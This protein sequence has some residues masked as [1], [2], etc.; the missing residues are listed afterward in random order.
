LNI[1]CNELKIFICYRNAK[2]SKEKI[3]NMVQ[4]IHDCETKMLDMQKEQDELE[5][6]GKVVMADLKATAVC[7]SVGSFLISLKYIT[8]HAGKMYGDIF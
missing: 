1:A 4:E 8:K 6:N 5:A 3:E 2:K 7:P